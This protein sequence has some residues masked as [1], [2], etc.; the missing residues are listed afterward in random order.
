MTSLFNSDVLKQTYLKVAGH[1][2]SRAGF[3]DPESTLSHCDVLS[4]RLV[5]SDASQVIL[6]WVVITACAVI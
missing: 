4:F 3:E 2:P 5:N 6:S 1:R